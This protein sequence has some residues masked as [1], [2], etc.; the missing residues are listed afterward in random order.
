MWNQSNSSDLKLI[1][2]MLGK[3][4][5]RQHFEIFFLFF[6]ENHIFRGNEKNHIDLSSAESAYSIVSVK[7]ISDQCFYLYCSSNS[8]T[9]Y[10]LWCAGKKKESNKVYLPS[11]KW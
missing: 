10:S 7:F 11:V 5:S 3:N 2:Y 1:C 9:G 8:W 4:F 6:A